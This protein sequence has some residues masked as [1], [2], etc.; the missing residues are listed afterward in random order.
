MIISADNHSGQD[1]AARHVFD[2][3]LA[4]VYSERFV[5]RVLVYEVDVWN[6]LSDGRR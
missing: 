2:D 1:I 5:V 6:Y 3:A 4:L